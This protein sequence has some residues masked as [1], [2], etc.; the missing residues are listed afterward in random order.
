[1]FNLMLGF[2]TEKPQSS[3]LEYHLGL[4]QRLLKSLEGQ[5]AT[6]KDT[7]W[8]IAL[9]TRDASYL[10]PVFGPDGPL[11]SAIAVI[12]ERN[13]DKKVVQR[14]SLWNG[15]EKMEKGSSLMCMFDRI[16]GA[17]SMLELTLPAPP[18]VSR[19]GDWRHTSEA[20]KVACSLFDPTY[21][22]LAPPLYEPIF[23]GRPGVGWMLYLPK[24]LTTQQVPE[25]RALVPVLG[26]DKKQKGT[27]IVSVTDTPF[28]WLDPEHVKLAHEI[29]IRLADQDLVPM[30]TEL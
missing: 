12:R 27:I 23:Q 25:A 9:G 19:L 26:S 14:F 11:P 1:M 10:Y 20:M 3:S 15:H 6:L 4:I 17:S 16:D 2:K 8:L 22:R 29:E 13:K 7:D 28:S 18:G 21:A 30:Y 5:D 24:K